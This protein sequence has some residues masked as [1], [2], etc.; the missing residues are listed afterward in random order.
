MASPYLYYGTLTAGT[1]G[2]AIPL[3]DALLAGSEG[4]IV[5]I[6]SVDTA[7][8]VGAYLVPAG[9]AIDAPSPFYAP[10]TGATTQMVDMYR[11]GTDA[12]D[13]PHLYATEDVTCYV[14]VRTVS[15]GAD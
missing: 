15:A 8:T 5:V 10:P 9:E 11:G 1:S 14:A 2:V 3:T 13:R 12:A 4:Q 7:E 6:V